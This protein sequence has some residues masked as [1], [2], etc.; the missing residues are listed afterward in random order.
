MSLS[1]HDR[2]DTGMWRGCLAGAG[3]RLLPLLA[4]ALLAGCGTFGSDRDWPPLPEFVPGARLELAW[5]VRLKGSPIYHPAPAVI[6]QKSVILAGVDGVVERRDDGQQKWRVD[7]D[8]PL[9]A[10]VGS[11]GRLAVVIDDNRGLHDDCVI[12]PRRC[13]E[14]GTY[15]EPYAG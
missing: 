13:R 11:D 1:A 4:V 5:K 8:L 6:G 2:S 10:G 9:S 3:R 12:V 14:L 7:L 15:C